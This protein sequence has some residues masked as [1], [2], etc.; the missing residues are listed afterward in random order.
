LRLPVPLS[1][2]LDGMG[3]H[4]AASFEAV[5]NRLSE[6]GVQTCEIMLQRNAGAGGC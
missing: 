2:V 5:L 3:E 4:V 6:A 1:V